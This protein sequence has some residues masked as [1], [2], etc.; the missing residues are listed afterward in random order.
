MHQLVASAVA[1]LASTMVWA[2]SGATA[3]LDQQQT[4]GNAGSA[5][6]VQPGPRISP[7]LTP[8]EELKSAMIPFDQA[9]RQPDDLTEADVLALRVG[10]NQAAPACVRIHADGTANIAPAELLALSRLCLFGHQFLQAR[11]AATQYLQLE[12]EPDRRT[13]KEL[14]TQAFLGLHDTSNAAVQVRSL[15]GETTYD[16]SLHTLLMQVIGTGALRQGDWLHLTDDLCAAEISDSLKQLEAGTGFPGADASSPGQLY[17]DTLTC[18][19]VIALV[20]DPVSTSTLARARDLP[21]SPGWHA[22]AEQLPMQMAL[23]RFDLEQKQSPVLRIDAKKIGRSGPETPRLLDL[24]HGSFLL[25]PSTLWAADTARLVSDLV[26]AAPSLPI[27]LL[28]SWAANTGGRDQ[29]DPQT[30]AGLRGL[31]AQIPSRVSVLIVPDQILKQFHIDVYP[32]AI[33]GI[34]GTVKLDTALDSETAER[35]TLIPLGFVKVPP[36][37]PRTAS[38]K[39]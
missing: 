26:S 30:L 16:A 8:S 17:R 19:R 36:A 27:Y 4:R 39:P 15:L 20:H 23:E 3:S 35:M 29:P 10:R 37:A 5:Q 11:N 34:D 21:S 31:A 9:R 1:L 25:V 28:T 33:T 22:S 24:Q 6:V 38:P 14:L 32:A 7:Q 13:A 2:Q 18:V 12:L